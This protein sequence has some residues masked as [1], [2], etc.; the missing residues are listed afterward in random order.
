MYRFLRKWAEEW[1]P[2]LYAKMPEK[3]EPVAKGQ[4]EPKKR[5]LTEK[6]QAE[7]TMEKVDRVPEIHA[8]EKKGTVGK[9]GTKYRVLEL[10]TALGRYR[11]QDGDILFGQD[12]SGMDIRLC[13]EE[14]RQLAA[15]VPEVLKVLEVSE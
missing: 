13:P 7:V 10:E 2:D 8:P 12:G 15:E 11:M 4:Q 5:K 1:Q 6:K 3:L 9:A 14:W